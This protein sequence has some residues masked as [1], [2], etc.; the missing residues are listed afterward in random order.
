MGYQLGILDWIGTVMVMV[1][2]MGIGMGMGMVCMYAC[3]H[4]WM[5]GWRYACIHTCLYVCMY[6]CTYMYICIYHITFSHQTQ[7]HKTQSNWLWAR[8]NVGRFGWWFSPRIPMPKFDPDPL[9]GGSS[10]SFRRSM[11]PRKVWYSLISINS[12]F[13]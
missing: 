8:S 2:V 12:Y 13:G 10:L 3:L 7:K 5:Y 1:L 11:F 4:V 9:L 6:A